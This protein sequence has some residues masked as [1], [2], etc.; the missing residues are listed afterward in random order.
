MK[1]IVIVAA[2]LLLATAVHADAKQRRHVVKRSADSGVT[3]YD[4]DS[5]DPE[6]GWHTDA[7]GMRSCSHDCDNP[8]ISGSG[9]RC[10]DVNFAGMAMRECVTGSGL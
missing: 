3:V 1:H 10:R 4:R 2:A 6:V 5:P 8:E 7:S 9:A